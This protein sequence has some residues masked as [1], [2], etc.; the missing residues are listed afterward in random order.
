M[1]TRH[2]IIDTLIGELTLVATDD[3]ITGVYFPHHWTKPDRARFGPRVP[4]SDDALL[5][6]AQT[7]LNEYL[8]GQR[9]HFELPISAEGDAFQR[10]VWAMLEQ[11]P[12]GTTTTY[13]EL[14]GQ[15]GDPSL[16]QLVGKAVGHNPM[17]IIIGCH[18]VVGKNGKLTG[19]AGGLARKQFLLELEEPAPMT[20]G[21]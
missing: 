8:R 16:A 6:N 12:F 9:T 4:V 11:I 17:S 20:A 10:R 1:T 7:Q 21:R 3:A 14:A 18:R 2:T 5:A 13:G 15:L 19:Y